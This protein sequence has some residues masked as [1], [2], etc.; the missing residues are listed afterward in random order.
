MVSL[1][2]KLVFTSN[3]SGQLQLAPALDL[4]QRAYTPRKGFFRGDPR[5]R[6][7]LSGCISGAEDVNC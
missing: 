3:I 2:I 6:I 7:Q 4:R 5:A 1:Y